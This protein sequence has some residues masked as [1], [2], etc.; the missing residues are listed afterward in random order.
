MELNR[1]TFSSTLQGKEIKLEV[2]RLAGQA[3]A[4]VLGYY[5]ETVVLAAVVMGNEDPGKDYFPLSVDYEERFYATGKILGS[6]FIR[7]EG[8]PSDEAV[9]SSRLI[10]RTIRPLFDETFKR[11]VQVVVTV[12]SYDETHDPDSIAL[13]AASTALSISDI[14]WNGPVAGVPLEKFNGDGSLRYRGFFAGPKGKI[15]MMELE[16]IEADSEELILVFEKSSKEIDQLIAFQ[17]KIVKEIGK[18]KVAIAQIKIPENLE[19]TIRKFIEPKLAAAI[20][21]KKLDE[22]KAALIVELEQQNKGEELLAHV[23][24]IFE[25]IVYEFIHNSAI[26]SGERPDGRTA[27]QIRDLHSEIG[28]FPRIHGTGLFIRG[29]TQILAATTLATPAAEQLVETMETSGKRRFMLHYNFPSFSTGETG[30]SRG[31]GRREIGHG[32]LAQKAIANMLPSKDDF[33][34]AIRVVAETLSSNGSS[35]M[36]TVCATTLSLMDA[37]VPIKKPVAGISMGLMSESDTKYKI[38]TDIQG[39]EDRYG[40]MDLKIAGTRDGVTAIQMDVKVYGISKKIFEEALVGAEKAR[41]HILDVIQKTIAEPRKELR[42][43][44]PTILTLHIPPEKI[45]M[46]IGPGGKTIN[47]IIDSVGGDTSIDIEDDGT[48][49][50]SGTNRER[51]KTAFTM[52]QQIVREYSVG[53]IIEG[54]IIKILDFGAILDLGGGKDGMIH[55][56]ELKDGFVKNVEDV[57]HVGDHVRARVVRVDPDGRIGLSLKNIPKE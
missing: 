22:V 4:S 35:S 41:L 36:A 15:N 2:S 55:V 53:E 27:D 44:V 54:D 49:F 46:V 26:M 20:K 56:S 10:D 51:A 57:I 11:E 19:S 39:P 13:L 40:D 30:R 18:E 34:Y 32:A 6:R 8:R 52:V 9:L 25:K 31:P 47:G 21:T 17:E 23:P 24:V 33:P 42:P 1:K 37:G 7:R 14:P 29:E 12:L 48:V 45:G 28:L 50:V 3:N 5:G 38:L 16:A 43:T